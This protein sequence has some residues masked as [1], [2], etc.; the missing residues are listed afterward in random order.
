MQKWYSISV[1]GLL[2]ISGEK[3]LRVSDRSNVG[4]VRLSDCTSQRDALRKL[5]AQGVS[6]TSRGKADRLFQEIDE[7]TNYASAPLV[8][9]SGWNGGHFVL[10]DGSCFSPEEAETP[11]IVIDAEKGKCTTAG[12]LKGWKNTVARPLEGQA[13]PMLAIMIAL[14]PPLLRLSSRADNFGFELVG[15]PGTGKTTAQLIAASVFG[16]VGRGDGACYWITFNATVNALEAQMAVHSDLPMIIEEA[17][18]FLAGETPS[19]RAAAFKA[20][21][22]K[23]G[24]GKSKERFGAPPERSHRVSY[25]S[26]SNESL[27]SLIGQDSDVAMATGDRLVTL[28]IRSNGKLGVFTSRPEAWSSTSEFAAAVVNGAAA[29][30]GWPGRRF[31]KRLVRARAADEDGLR[32]R[33]QELVQRF[34]TIRPCPALR[35]LFMTFSHTIMLCGSGCLYP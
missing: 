32:L 3:W 2:S 30:H 1:K 34:T 12:T 11:V 6:L 13:V 15:P 7:I 31:L 23:I 19:K 17:N 35:N 18:L 20:I 26:S 27:A 4:F 28:D 24:G 14:M 21:A 10:P 29:N 33:I 22:F 25:L 16:G 9:H 8:D 5:M